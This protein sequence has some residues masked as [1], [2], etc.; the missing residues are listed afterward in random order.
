MGPLTL[1]GLSHDVIVSGHFS[2]VVGIYNLEGSVHRGLLP[3]LK[4]LDW[5]QTI[6]ISADQNHL[7]TRF[8]AQAALWTLSRLSYFALAV[9]LADMWFLLRRR[10]RQTPRQLA[11]R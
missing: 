9:L 5:N 10:R 1:G 4:A 7:M 11:L 2:P 3:R 8:R 6:F